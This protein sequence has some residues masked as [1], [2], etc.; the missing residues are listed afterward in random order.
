V[1]KA[2]LYL[3]QQQAGAVRCCVRVGGESSDATAWL[4]WGAECSA[5]ERI[6]RFTLSHFDRIH[7]QRAFQSC[8]SRDDSPASREEN[9][10]AARVEKV[11]RPG[12]MRMR[13]V[14][15][16]GRDR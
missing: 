3:L 10:I 16:E 13:Q 6:V 15:A 1:N 11:F 9:A 5:G 8:C 4:R 14:Y 7:S 2:L 12:L